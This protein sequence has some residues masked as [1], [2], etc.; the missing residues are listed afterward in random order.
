MIHFGTIVISPDFAAAKSGKCWFSSC[1]L[2]SWDGDPSATRN[3][4]IETLS[5]GKQAISYIVNIWVQKTKGF[6]SS[7]PPPDKL[8]TD[9]YHALGMQHG[10]PMDWYPGY[11]IHRTGLLNPV[12]KSKVPNWKKHVPTPFLAIKPLYWPKSIPDIYIYILTIIYIS[13][14]CFAFTLHMHNCTGTLRPIIHI[15]H[16]MYRHGLRVITSSYR[17]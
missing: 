12:L 9:Q 3:S 1:Q 2:I 5:I 13:W 15:N 7:T 8:P 17:Y 10:S 6:F 11:P 16:P 14:T 4:E